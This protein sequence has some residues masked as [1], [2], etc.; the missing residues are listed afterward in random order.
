MINEVVELIK[1]QQNEANQGLEKTQIMIEKQQL[2]GRELVTI[3]NQ[4]IKEANA[5]DSVD[6]RINLLVK[7]L[8]DINVLLN[9]DLKN[10][11]SL[12]LK[13]DTELKLLNQLSA[14]VMAQTDKKKDKE[15]DKETEEEPEK[16]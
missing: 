11:D 16:D 10:L 4:A 9:S 8:S 12:L 1:N 3:I 14:D 13:Y 15:K 2:F 5:T 7:G 6:E